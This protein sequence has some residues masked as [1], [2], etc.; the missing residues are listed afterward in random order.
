MFDG[1]SSVE[2]DSLSGSLACSMRP[3]FLAYTRPQLE[4]VAVQNLA[5]QNF[6]AYLPLYKRLK[7]V[8]DGDSRV[9]LEPMFPRYVFFR[10]SL[11]TQSIAPVRSTRGVSHV[12]RFGHET[13]TIRPGILD[14]IRQFEEER[15]AA[16]V[17]E[18]SALRPGDKV[19][20]SNPAFKG[21]EGL[22]K[23]VS[24][25]RVSVLLELMGRPQVLKVEHHLLDV[26]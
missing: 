7:K 11:P 20:F 6:D 16:D 3:W 18:L 14:V 19:R 17:A 21:L 10:P 24:S 4:A 12:V 13:A 8:P 9:V 26:M 1:R 22:V 5:L 25:R 15:N 23:S 2:D